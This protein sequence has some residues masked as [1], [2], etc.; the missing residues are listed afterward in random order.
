MFMSGA[1]IGMM[2]NYYKNSPKSNPKGPEYGL[3][4]G[5]YAVAR[6]YNFPANL[7]CSDRELR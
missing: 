6:G 2:K 4:A 7:R 5:F 3:L 1:G